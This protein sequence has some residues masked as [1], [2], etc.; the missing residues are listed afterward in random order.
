MKVGDLVRHREKIYHDV[1]WFG[2]VTM[3]R[4]RLRHS[5]VFVVWATGGHGWQYS[6]DLE[7]I[8]ESR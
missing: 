6:S 7:V 4:R 1:T 3:E 8:N 2:I 5:K